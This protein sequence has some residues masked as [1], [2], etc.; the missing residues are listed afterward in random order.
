MQNMS[1]AKESNDLQFYRLPIIVYPPLVMQICFPVQFL[2]MDSVVGIMSE[3][4]VTNAYHLLVEYQGLL[5]FTL[6]FSA[7]L[8]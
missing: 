4:F 6:V 1:H 8:S 7:T 3:S 5:L 2:V